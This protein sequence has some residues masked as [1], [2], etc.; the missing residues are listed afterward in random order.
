MQCEFL[1]E[2]YSAAD[3]R[4]RVLWRID[5]MLGRHERALAE[6][7]NIVTPSNADIDELF[8]YLRPLVEANDDVK[9]LLQSYLPALI[10][11]R[12]RATAC[13]TGDHLSNALILQSI[14]NEQIIEFGQSLLEAGHLRGDSATVHLRNLC[15]YRPNDV[16][17]FLADNVGLVRPEEALAIVRTEGPPEAEPFCLEAVGDPSA[18]LDAILRLAAANKDERLSAYWVGAGGALC[19][20]VAPGLPPEAAAELWARL[21]RLARAPPPTLL[22][23]A[24]KYLPAEEA[25]RG[26]SVTAALALLG[27]A[28]GR[29]AAWQ[30]AGRA[31]AREAHTGLARALAAARRGVAV[32][33]RCVRCARRLAERT[34]RTGHCARAVHADCAP[35]SSCG[36]CGRR[37]SAADL[38]LPSR[39]SRRRSPPP[40]DF[41][42]YLVA[43]PRPD[44]EGA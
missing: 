35:E 6:F 9:N 3:Q 24:A 39:T 43:P 28:A 12:P 14:S 36:Q 33:G 38:T 4:P 34:V 25:L 16:K 7:F 13:L 17:S 26:A 44:L 11:L 41:E 42:L 21:L 40:H 27:V 31:A 23:E 32:R 37:V 19:A 2:Q 15:R 22:L 18:A 30:C 29:R 1:E 10:K 5:A 20:R 8:E